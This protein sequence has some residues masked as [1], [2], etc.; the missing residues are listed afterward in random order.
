MDGYSMLWQEVSECGQFRCT[1]LAADPSSSRRLD[2]QSSICSSQ[3]GVQE[4]V[5][6][7]LLPRFLLQISPQSCGSCG[8]HECWNMLVSLEGF[9]GTSG[10][11]WNYTQAPAHQRP[12]SPGI[13]KSLQVSW[14]TDLAGRC[15]ESDRL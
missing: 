6:M 1:S 10:I 13:T 14:G 4:Y 12:G 8:L 9:H 7:A 15:W 3:R 11:T 5:R 2:M